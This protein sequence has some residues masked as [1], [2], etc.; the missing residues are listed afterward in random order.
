[1]P[2]PFSTFEPPPSSCA[3]RARHSPFSRRCGVLPR[4]TPLGEHFRRPLLRQPR[5][6]SFWEGHHP[7]SIA[8]Q[9]MT[10]CPRDQ[11]SDMVLNELNIFPVQTRHA[12][13][14]E[15]RQTG[16]CTDTRMRNS[17]ARG[18]IA[19]GDLWSGSRYEITAWQGTMVLPRSLISPSKTAR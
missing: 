15:G 7:R 11:I 18:S 4:V 16:R 10:S 3:F 17:N 8:S 9:R 2:H 6:A 1:M 19:P 5:H 12:A 14:R 13:F